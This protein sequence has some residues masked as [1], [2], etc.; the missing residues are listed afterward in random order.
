VVAR[1]GGEGPRRLAMRV[2][3][4]LAAVAA[5]AV[6][7]GLCFPPRSWRGLA[8]IALVPLLV[9][10]RRVTW[11]RALLHAWVWTAVLACKVNDW[12]PRA[13]SGYFAEP[14]AIGI[15]LFLGVTTFTGSLQYMAFA[16][17]YQRLVR[18]RSVAE[19]YLTAAAWV[20][21]DLMRLL[22]FGGDP[23]ALLGYSQVGVL[24]LIQVAD[25]TGVHGVTFVLVAVNAGLRVLRQLGRCGIIGTPKSGYG[26]DVDL[27]S[28]MIAVL[29]ITIAEKKKL[30]L[31]GA[32]PELPR[33]TFCTA[34]GTPY[35]PRNVLR[36]WYRLQGKAKLLDADG[37]PRF[38]L[39]SFRHTFASLHILNGAKLSWLQ[40]LGHSDVRLTRTTYGRWFKLRDLTAA[41]HQD[42]R[43]RLVVTKAVTEGTNAG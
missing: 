19:P 1:A 6:A 13:V 39:H 32:F 7:Y 14:A 5:S 20:G 30:E 34:R 37:A 18:R 36:D 40:E 22:L 33:W 29:K 23:W 28:D 11:R 8:W 12:F 21:A 26:R 4:Q 16:I 31:A 35:S 10:L 2:I 38:D 17:V 25:V 43:S 41:D 9:V 24:P 15:G 42:A 27:S 3:A